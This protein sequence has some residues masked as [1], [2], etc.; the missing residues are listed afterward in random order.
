M[1]NPNDGKIS[2]LQDRVLSMRYA[3]F[4]ITSLSPC[5]SWSLIMG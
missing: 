5:K 3:F 4:Q 2:I 1:C